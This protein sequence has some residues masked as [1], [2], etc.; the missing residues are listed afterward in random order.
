ML[1]NKNL[2]FI[3]WPVIMGQ[4]NIIS[5]ATMASNTK[6]HNCKDYKKK[7]KEKHEQIL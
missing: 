1:F 5:T 4:P 3:N 6:F 7:N 2:S